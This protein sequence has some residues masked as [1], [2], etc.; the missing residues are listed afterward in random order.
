LFQ[1][2]LLEKKEEAIARALA[3]DDDMS[4]ELKQN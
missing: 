4:E 2:K 3:R 1:V